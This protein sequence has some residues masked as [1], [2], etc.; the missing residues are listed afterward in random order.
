M[1]ILSWVHTKL[2]ERQEKKIRFNQSYLPKSEFP[3]E[4]FSDWPHGLLAIGTCGRNELKSEQEHVQELPQG[5]DSDFTIEEVANLQKEL[6]KLLKN[7]SKWGKTDEDTGKDK[8]N[9]PLDK[10]LNCPSSLEVDRASSL[11][12]TDDVE[13]GGDG[14][15]LSPD[16]RII[17]SKA[18]Y[19]L[20]ENHNLIKKKPISFL[21]KSLFVCRS[22]F[23][24][25]PSLRDPIAELKIEKALKIILYKKIY[26]QSSTTMAMKKYLENRTNVKETP[27]EKSQEKEESK[28]K[29]VKTDSE[30]I[31]L[32][33]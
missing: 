22:G 20:A 25:A 16:S 8:A 29:W 13:D 7:K 19:L 12:L 10:F 31:V 6:S 21:L 14:G 4:E 27:K 15:D 26:P 9:L 24:L 2:K 5:L 30:F 11:R 1:R 18:R 32:E 17:L 33:M 3:N 23:S 28:C